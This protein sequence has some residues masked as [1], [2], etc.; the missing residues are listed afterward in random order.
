MG[1]KCMKEIAVYFNTI[2]YLPHDAYC[3]PCYDRRENFHQEVPA[4][5]QHYEAAQKIQCKKAF[6]P[7]YKLKGKMI[8]KS[9]SQSEKL[10]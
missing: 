10:V 6:L 8:Q 1:L 2:L 5:K 9:N 7:V 3:K 4:P